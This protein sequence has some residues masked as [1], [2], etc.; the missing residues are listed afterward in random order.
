MLVVLKGTHP[1]EGEL[2]NEFT[3]NERDT[4]VHVGKRWL[5]KGWRPRLFI[6]SFDGRF[7]WLTSSLAER[8]AA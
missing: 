5:A 7:T 2:C 3:L 6:K 4:A 8:K 1:V